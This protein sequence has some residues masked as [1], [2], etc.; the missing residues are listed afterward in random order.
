MFS[1]PIIIASLSTFIAIVLLRP[2][3][4]SINLTDKPS[5]RKFHTGSVPLI[6][7]IAMFFG[8]A[9]SILMLPLDLNDYNFF[10]LSSIIIVSIGVLDDH[11]DISV[12][13]RL[14][15]QALV[16]IIIISGGNLS[17]LSFGNLFGAGEILLNGWA[18]FVTFLGII[19]NDSYKV[20]FEDD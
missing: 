8:M 10:F 19:A 13:L 18:Y 12:E 2:F 15:F 6:G 14:L 3:A 5:N 16:A 1:F 17:I 11:R 20:S 4:L 9:I 7:G